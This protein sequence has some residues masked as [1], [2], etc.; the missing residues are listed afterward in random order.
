M[1]FSLFLVV[2]KLVQA[3]WRVAMM[4]RCLRDESDEELR[5]T[6]LAYLPY[7]IHFLGVSANALVFQ[8]VHPAM[9][10]E[11]SPRVLKAY[12]GLLGPLCCLVSRKCM[13]MRRA[14]FLSDH[15][16]SARTPAI[17]RQNES[18]RAGLSGYFEIVCTCCDKRRIDL[19]V[20]GKLARRRNLELF[21]VLY[22]RPKNVDTQMLVPFFHVLS[23]KA[24][25][26]QPSN[27]NANNHAETATATDLES[28]LV[29]IRCKLLEHLGRPFNHLEFGRHLHMQMLVSPEQLN[30]DT[31]T[32][33]IS[34]R[35]YT[36][37]YKEALALLGDESIDSMVRFDFARFS[38]PKLIAATTS[39]STTG[40]DSTGG[41][42]GG[43]G[44]GGGGGGATMSTVMSEEMVHMAMNTS[45]FGHQTSNM[46]SFVC[47]FL[48]DSITTLCFAK[49]LMLMIFTTT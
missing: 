30:D 25:L 10:D 15:S 11:R 1:C 39:L 8:L 47:E 44:G 27:N 22:N 2:C 23:G 40:G 5:V 20:L 45:V 41:V 3:Q 14:S 24:M 4:T 18:S 16:S 37:I 9:G 6:A 42:S 35:N 36:F 49:Y 12:A 17:D 26:K 7:L 48:S 43:G 46:A 28:Q 31:S 34:H 21:Q 38:I 32:N 19:D 33:A 13:V 29:A